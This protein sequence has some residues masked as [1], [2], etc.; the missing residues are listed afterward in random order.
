MITF[1]LVLALMNI[2]NV[3]TNYI[4]SLDGFQSKHE[5]Q[6]QADKWLVNMKK[7]YGEGWAYTAVCVEQK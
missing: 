4:R 1:S 3:S 7:E 6:V 5:C 2:H